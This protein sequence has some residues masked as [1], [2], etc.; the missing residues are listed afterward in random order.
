M[1]RKHYLHNTIVSYLAKHPESPLAQ[2]I[3]KTWSIDIAFADELDELWADELYELGELLDQKNNSWYILKPGMSDRGMGIRL[4]KTKDDLMRIL[5]SFDDDDDEEEE[6][7]DDN[8]TDVA[9]SQL[10]HF[11]IQVRPTECVQIYRPADS[12]FS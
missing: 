10:R 8:P 4:F 1:I 2:A 12:C 9:I 6:R 5:H 3:P 11:V 7:E